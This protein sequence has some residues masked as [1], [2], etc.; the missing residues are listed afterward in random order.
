MVEG[1]GDGF[2]T[3]EIILGAGRVFE[4]LRRLVAPLYWG[5]VARNWHG[6]RKFN[7]GLLFCNHTSS[8]ESLLELCRLEKN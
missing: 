6:I 4:V 2:G 7:V 3:A 8:I 1:G 5:I